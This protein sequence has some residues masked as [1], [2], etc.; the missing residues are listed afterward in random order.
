MKSPVLKKRSIVV[1]GHRTSVSLEDEF[2]ASLRK[3]AKE[4]DQ[5][6]SHLISEIN[7]CR[8]FANLSSAIRLFILR[9]YRGQADRH[10]EKAP[11]SSSEL[12]FSAR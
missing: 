6:I 3:I 9:Y 10:S 7:E 8:D 11:R 4:R 1:V 5:G 12:F 2:W